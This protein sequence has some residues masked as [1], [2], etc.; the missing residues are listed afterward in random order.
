MIPNSVQGFLEL[1][2]LCSYSYQKLVVQ[3]WFCLQISGYEIT[4]LVKLIVY[5]LMLK[6]SLDGAFSCIKGAN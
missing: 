5:F 1:A 2:T 4:P 6:V 3:V